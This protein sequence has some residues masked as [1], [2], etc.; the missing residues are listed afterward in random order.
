MSQLSLV[1]TSLAFLVFFCAAIF[2]EVNF[3]VTGPEHPTTVS[4]LCLDFSAH[5]LSKELEMDPVLFQ[6]SMCYLGPPSSKDFQPTD[7]FPIPTFRRFLWFVVDGWSR[8]YS[9]QTF[10]DYSMN[11]ASFL[12]NVPSIKYSHV[13][14]SSLLTGTM[15]SNFAMLPLKSDHLFASFKRGG[16]KLMY[17]GPEF[18]LLAIHGREQYDKIFDTINLVNEEHTIDFVHPFPTL[19][20]PAH[21]TVPSPQDFERPPPAFDTDDDR[22]ITQNVELFLD[23]LKER[24][25][26]LVAHSGVF[27]HVAHSGNVTHALQIAATVSCDLL[28]LKNWLSRNPE[29]LLIVSSDHGV[30]RGKYGEVLHGYSGE[31][32]SGIVLLHNQFIN[33]STLSRTPGRCKGPFE[34]CQERWIE[35]VDLAATL[36]PLLTG[37]DI[38]FSAV[39]LGRPLP[40]NIH[41]K[42]KFYT[43]NF[44]Q[45]LRAAKARGLLTKTMKQ[46]AVKFL[47]QY[48]TFSNDTLQH[49]QKTYK[50]DIRQTMMELSNRLMRLS[51]FP[52][53]PLILTIFFVL[54]ASFVVLKY[55]QFS[56]FQIVVTVFINSYFLASHFLLYKTP[57]PSIFATSLLIVASVSLL[58]SQ[59]ITWRLLWLMVLNHSIGLV[60]PIV[61][62]Q[63]SDVLER[64][65]LS[66]AGRSAMYLVVGAMLTCHKLCCHHPVR[67]RVSKIHSLVTGVIAFVGIYAETSTPLWLT[68]FLNL[69]FLPI[70]ML[71]FTQFVISLPLFLQFPRHIGLW[72]S[73]FVF[74]IATVVPVLRCAVI[75]MI[76]KSIVLFSIFDH[77]C[78]RTEGDRCILS[79][80]N[81]L[82]LCYFTVFQTISD[83]TL[84]QSDLISLSVK[85]QFGRAGIQSDNVY[86]G[87][88]AT[89]MALSK[90]Y[91][92]I[93][94]TF[95]LFDSL[96][97][98]EPKR[99][100]VSQQL[101]V[102]NSIFDILS[103]SLFYRFPILL[104]AVISS[105][106]RLSYRLSLWRYARDRCFQM[107]FTLTMTTLGMT[108]LMAFCYTVYDGY[109]W[110]CIHTRN[111]HHVD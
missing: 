107:L 69:K 29:Y 94:I 88:S 28:R 86:P 85:P 36:S 32:N 83:L 75:A 19:F 18:S 11:G 57:D 79:L 2:E 30:D 68:N 73:F 25:E 102:S 37:T 48:T 89:C 59:G 108:T 26:S 40:D 81:I 106:L 47:Q 51:N 96:R 54:L 38:P 95:A 46:K 56:T 77:I 39:G 43:Q 93:S 111:R 3:F 53:I 6:E 1:L 67:H 55:C 87:F 31:G 14:Y 90:F 10:I 97:E 82:T 8:N 21:C 100:T 71:F 22:L 20:L 24:G 60:I 78:G 105:L 27:D 104:F 110:W 70:Y 64:F 45:L 99:R 35:T 92:I 62:N 109:K 12:L 41:Y 42:S 98:I 9:N 13:I 91:P 7:N 5:N 84:L 66:L 101:N 50:Y 16:G 23:M 61:I 4:N 33:S 103:E 63:Y 17:L 76:V 49:E 80:F 52:Y 58:I 74:S 65:A 72:F 15:V 44:V 34:T